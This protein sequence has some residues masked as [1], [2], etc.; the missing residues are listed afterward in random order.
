MTVDYFLGLDLGQSI[1]FT[2]LSILERER[3]ITS[4]LRPSKYRLPRL[5]ETE[6][7]PNLTCLYLK[8]YA[9]GTS[10][11]AIVE[12]VCGIAA[13]PQIAGVEVVV[14][15]TGVGRPIVDLFRA[16][17]RYLI[18]IT[19][20]GGDSVSREGHYWRVPKR[21]LIGTLVSAAQSKRLKLVSDMPEVRTLE[22]ELLNFRVKI[23]ETGHDSYSHRDGEHDDLVLSL[24][25]GCWWAS[26][27]RQS[28]T[29]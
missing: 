6:H 5:V 17:L 19:I 22:Q 24:A 20:H 4:E 13:D 16:R 28:I 1:D 12:D 7:P 9:I 3:V 2:A 26:R 14:D 15:G 10:Y 11:P 29:W 27:P 18:A 23:S 21:D 25:L 8:R